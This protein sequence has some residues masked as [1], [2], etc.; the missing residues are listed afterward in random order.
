M[1]SVQKRSRRGRKLWL[2]AIIVAVGLMVVGVSFLRGWYSDNLRPVSSS[3]EITYFTVS[4]GDSRDKIAENLK[5]VGL[6]R[7]PAAFKNYIRTNE[8]MN[9][10]AGTYKLSPSMSVQE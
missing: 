5:S 1:Y 4:S 6:I 3:Q 2:I 9:L 8:V 10:Q 7:N